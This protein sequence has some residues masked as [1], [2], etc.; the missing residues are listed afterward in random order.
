MPTSLER[1]TVTVTS[2]VRHCLDIASRR[3]PDTK[4]PRVLM[5]R[6]MEEG[7]TTLHEKDLEAAY[8]DAYADWDASEDAAL[9]NAAVGDGIGDDV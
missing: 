2:P 8:A 4:S 5:V 1:V 7:A 9:W 3:W 6:L